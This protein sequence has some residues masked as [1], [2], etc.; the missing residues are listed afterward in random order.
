MIMLDRYSFAA[1]SLL[2]VSSA[3]ILTAPL[4]NPQSTNAFGV[5][6]VSS[7][8]NPRAAF[9]RDSESSSL[10][11]SRSTSNSGR[12]DTTTYTLV[13][14]PFWNA[15][16]G[17]TEQPHD[18]RT[19]SSLSNSE[20]TLSTTEPTPYNNVGNLQA[21]EPQTLLAGAAVLALGGG[22][23]LAHSLGLSWS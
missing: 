11:V 2:V 3:Y 15:P 14:P 12:N 20:T 8:T 1:L 23:A 9:R 22:V 21:L 18:A 13:P 10:Q 7:R 16:T 17:L 5:R 19:P 4:R 6:S